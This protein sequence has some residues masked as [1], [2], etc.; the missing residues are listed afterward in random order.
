MNKR[1]NVTANATLDIPALETR[2]AEYL[3]SNPTPKDVEFHA[4]A[5][6]LGVDKNL[7][8]EICYRMLSTLLITAGQWNLLQREPREMDTLMYMAGCDCSKQTS[9]ILKDTGENLSSNM[10]NLALRIRKADD[11]DRL[12]M[13]RNRELSYAEEQDLSEAIHKKSSDQTS[14]NDPARITFVNEQLEALGLTQAEVD[15]A[16]R[17]LDLDHYPDESALINTSY[18]SLR[19]ALIS[20]TDDVFDDPEFQDLKFVFSGL[21]QDR[22]D[23]GAQIRVAKARQAARLMRTLASRYGVSNRGIFSSIGTR[24]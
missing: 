15:T 8:E 24:G 9:K 19:E 17:L 13:E 23:Q 16:L 14:I 11:I 2:I 3:I 1:K 7:L 6:G 5:A 22:R 21:A 20:R 10:I 18:N 12:T 4:F